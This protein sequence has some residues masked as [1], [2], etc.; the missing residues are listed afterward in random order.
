MNN[1]AHQ[2][3]AALIQA[4]AQQHLYNAWAPQVPFTYGLPLPNTAVAPLPNVGLQLDHA[5]DGAVSEAPSQQIL[6]RDYSFLNNGA[7]AEFAAT[8]PMAHSVRGGVGANHF[9]TVALTPEEPETD[10]MKIALIPA[11]DITPEA[12][13]VT[14]PK[15]IH[16]QS[17]PLNRCPQGAHKSRCA[18]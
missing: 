16:V 9:G 5:N 7:P 12:A 1:D 15:P 2:H 4:R 10:P 11:M 18:V 13:V 3:I 14:Y 8:D 6:Q 17:L